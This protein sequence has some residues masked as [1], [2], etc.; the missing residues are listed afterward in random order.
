M[1]RNFPLLKSFQF[2]VV[3]VDKQGNI[4]QRETKKAENFTEDLGNGRHLEILALPGGKFTRGSPEGEGRLDEKPQDSGTV[5]PFFIGKFQ[6]TQKQWK[7]FTF[8]CV[9]GER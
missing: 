6:V 2:K 1:P 5:S 7:G 9:Y 8:M 4:I 3:V